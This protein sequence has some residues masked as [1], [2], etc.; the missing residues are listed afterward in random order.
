LREVTEEGKEGK[1]VT[2]ISS[3]PE[4]SSFFKDADLSET[5]GD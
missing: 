4:L 1:W 2:Q 3:H 5:E